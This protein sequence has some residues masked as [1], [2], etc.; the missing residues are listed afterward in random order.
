MTQNVVYLELLQ[1][2]V[3]NN[4]LSM[5][6]QILLGPPRSHPDQTRAPMRHGGELVF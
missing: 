5:R 6:L 2:T 3:R 1:L 4:M